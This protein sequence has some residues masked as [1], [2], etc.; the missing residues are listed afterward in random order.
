MVATDG[1]ADGPPGFLHLEAAVRAH[2]V[3]AWGLPIRRVGLEADGAL[4]ALGGR[5]RDTQT[6]VKMVERDATL[7]ATLHAMLG[8]GVAN[9]DATLDGGEA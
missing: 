6:E 3:A 1:A 9:L 2:V 4:D 7:H 8:G 5:G